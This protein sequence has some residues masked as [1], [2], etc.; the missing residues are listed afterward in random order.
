VLVLTELVRTGLVINTADVTDG[1]APAA[2][3]ATAVAVYWVPGASP[4]RFAV[5]VEELKVVLD[6]PTTGVTVTVYESIDS[7]PLDVGAVIATD[8]V[9]VAP[10]ATVPT[11]ATGAVGT[12][13][14]TPIETVADALFV[15][16]EISADALIVKF[17]AAVTVV[18]V[19]EIV[20]VAVSNESPAGSVPEIE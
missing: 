13:N 11:A 8:A 9:V 2:L 15:T 10:V 20:P 6:P 18:G 12:E 17:A 5:V 7:P 4:V 1:P 19:P 16:P 3:T 14:V